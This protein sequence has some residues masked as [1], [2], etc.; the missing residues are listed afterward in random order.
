MLAILVMSTCRVFSC[1]VG[2]ECSLWP[3]CS[4]G[5]T[6]LACALLHSVFQGQL[7]PFLQVFLDFLTFTFQFSI[8]KRTSFW[9]VISKMSQNSPSQTS[10]GFLKRQRNQ[11]SNCQHPLNQWKEFKRKLQRHI[12]FFFIDS[13]KDFDFV[14][15]KK[16]KK[17]KPVGNT[18]SGGNT[19]QPDLPL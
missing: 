10:A 14:D 8:M 12:D 7:C 15:H 13:A 4:L 1:V 3:V 6:L 18:E 19:R 2:R 11:R 9:G 17:K 16:K 5:K